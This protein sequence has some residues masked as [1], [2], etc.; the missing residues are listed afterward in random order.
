L[1]IY[2]AADGSVTDE[3]YSKTSSIEDFDFSP[4][5][6]SLSL[7]VENGEVAE[8]GVGTGK[9][10]ASF[11]LGNARLSHYDSSPVISFT[12]DGEQIVAADQKGQLHMISLRSSTIRVLS[13]GREEHVYF[14]I[15]PDKRYAATLS[16]VGVL[17]LW[18]LPLAEIVLEAR[19][20]LQSM[21]LQPTVRFSIDGRR[22][23]VDD[24]FNGLFIVPMPPS[25]SAL[26]AA[27]QATIASQPEP[28]RAAPGDPPKLRFGVIMTDMDASD[29][30]LLQI[31]STSGA[32]VTEVLGGSPAEE[33]GLRVHDVIL[34]FDGKPIADRSGVVAAVRDAAADT[35]IAVN[36][37][38]DGRRI[39]VYLTLP[40]RP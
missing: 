26:V 28:S 40:Q 4:D 14:A 6:Q 11:F 36:I 39:Q 19:L 27:V 17:R 31:G 21:S 8:W 20:L 29:R 34:E 18:N 9:L 12:R 22:L 37:W 7:A 33:A 1:R 24:S 25:G 30:E 38:R 15:S 3:I 16:K 23:I 5:G 13:S 2:R 32:L 35:R 10:T